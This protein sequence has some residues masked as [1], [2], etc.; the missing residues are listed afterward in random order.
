MCSVDGNYP[1]EPGSR[2]GA[3]ELTSGSSVE[4]SDSPSFP[5]SVG[6]KEL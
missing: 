4:G 1:L 5:G 6:R 2:D 3:G